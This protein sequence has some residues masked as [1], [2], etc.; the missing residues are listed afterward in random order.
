MTHEQVV[1]QESAVALAQEAMGRDASRRDTLVTAAIERI[2]PR[3]YAYA[4][5]RLKRVDA[6]DAVATAL[7]RVWR[8]RGVFDARRGEADAWAY[9]VGINAIRDAARAIGRRPPLVDLDD[10]QLAAADT[11]DRRQLVREIVTAMHQLPPAD[12]DLLALRY[13]AGLNNHEIGVQTNR[14]PGAVATAAHRAI[15]RLRTIVEGNRT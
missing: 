6:E 4:R 14:S 9:V 8:K 5:C 1:R 10:V 3:L 2:Y 7:E 15:A 11:A 13:G 12:A